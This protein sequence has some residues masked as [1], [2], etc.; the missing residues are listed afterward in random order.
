MKENFLHYVWQYKLFNLKNLKTTKNDDV[1]VIKSG[2]TN[3]NS[4]PD[5]LNAQVRINH[6][7]WVGNVEI[8]IKSSDWY[9]HKHENDERYDAV[10]LHIVWEDDVAVFMKNNVPLPTLELKNLV[11]DSLLKNYKKLLFRPQHFISCENQITKVDSFVIN[12]WLERLFFERLV[13]KS[14]LIK[15]LLLKSNNDYEAVM[16]QLLAKNFGLKVNGDAFL[17]MATSV[18]F[19][20]IRKVRF[21]ELQLGALLFG[22]AGFLLENLDNA[23]YQQL[24]KEYTFLRHKYQLASISKNQFQ[25]FRMRPSNFPT[26]RVAQLVALFS[27]H[28][29]IFSKL[30]EIDCLDDF[31]NLLAVSVDDFWQN[32]YTFEKSS[33]KSSKRLTKSFIDLLIINTIIP[34]KFNYLQSRGEVDESLFLKLALQIEPEKNSIISCFSDINIKVKNAFET[35]AL[36]ELKNNYCSTKKCLSC[37]IGNELLRKS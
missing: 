4:G 11:E 31:Y 1:V 15:S 10:I 25:F 17:Q 30:M 19:S 5:F 6:Q 16:F 21:S 35:Q 23:H 26:I 7:L 2:N 36:L 28:Q 3:N 34:L 33:K 12:H 32:H 27:S 18:D 14:N 22:Q 9:V 24:K 13:N 37:A 20:I 8:H 29:N